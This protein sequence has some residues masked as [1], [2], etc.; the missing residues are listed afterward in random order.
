MVH[1][2]AMAFESKAE[3]LRRAYRPNVVVRTD[4]DR[5]TLAKVS[6]SHIIHK[7]DIELPIASRQHI[8]DI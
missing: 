4:Q 6:K 7:S 5:G 1:D 8:F 3:I 2:G